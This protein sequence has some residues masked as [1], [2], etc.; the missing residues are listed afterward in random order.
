[1]TSPALQLLPFY[2]LLPTYSSCSLSA[3]DHSA[4]VTP[5]SAVNVWLSAVISPARFAD[6][7]HKTSSWIAD[8]CFASLYLI[9]DT[10]DWPANASHAERA[11]S[12]ADSLN[13]TMTRQVIEVETRPERWS[14]HSDS[15]RSR[16]WLAS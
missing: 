16:N 9:T 13:F 12:A 11:L 7:A 6:S 4:C 3:C 2:F 10:P 14:I 5:G 15:R 8:S 1:P